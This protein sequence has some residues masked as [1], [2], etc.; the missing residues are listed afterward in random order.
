MPTPPA[1]PLLRTL[2]PLEAIVYPALRIIAGAMFACHGIQKLFGVFG[3]EHAVPLFSQLGVGG[4]IELT[5]GV[6]IALGLF[7]RPAAFI[8]S[9]QMAVAFFQFHVAETGKILPIQSGADDTVLYC[10]VF[11]LF[12]VR[13]GGRAS[14]DHVLFP[15]KPTS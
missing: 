12:L 2:E 8:C 13:G 3:A 1:S 10:F 4:V 14:L 15:S 11:L 9:G 5:G 6:L 7:T